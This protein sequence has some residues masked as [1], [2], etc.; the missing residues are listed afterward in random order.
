MMH[1]IGGIPANARFT[2]IVAQF[3]ILEKEMEI[4][5]VKPRI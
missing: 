2:G 5:F 1:T 4:V 3:S